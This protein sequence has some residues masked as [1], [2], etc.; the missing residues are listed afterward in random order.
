MDVKVCKAPE[1]T[2]FEETD[3]DVVQVNT[4][5]RTDRR[6]INAMLCSD[7]DSSAVTNKIGNLGKQGRYNLKWVYLG[8]YQFV[9]FH[10]KMYMFYSWLVYLQPKLILDLQSTPT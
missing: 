10:L 7:Y 9:F 4:W 8:S 3:P 1:K 2:G 6:K 5:V